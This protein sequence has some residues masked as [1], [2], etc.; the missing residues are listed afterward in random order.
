MKVLF[1]GT[2]AL[3]IPYLE[4]LL[5]NET[6]VGVV[7]RPDEPVGRGYEIAPPPTKKL[8]KEL[9]LPVFQP[10]GP[11]EPSLVQSL[12]GLG[13]EVGIVVA[14]GR[15]IP[16]DVFL[17][18]KLGSLNVH[19]SLLP[20][21]RG[22]APIQW[23][24]IRGEKE[25]GV[26]LFWLEEGLD[27]GPLFSQAAQVISPE[28]DALTLREKLV[29]LG[30]DLL[31]KAMADLK[32]GRLPRKPQEGEVILAPPLKKEDGV[33]DWKKPAEEIVNL[34]RGVVEWPV[35]HTAFKDREGHSKQLKIYKAAVDS[36]PPGR[37][38]QPGE[39][40]EG[41]INEGLLVQAGEGRLL[42]RQVQPESGKLM[43]AWAFWQ[44][45]RLP[46]GTVLGK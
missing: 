18:P 39:I 21:Y 11:W 1:F 30:V 23:S 32:A 33:I 27:S 4:W 28:D 29:P 45:A 10:K 22:A 26:S 15:I 14:Y 42:L 6:V 44:G 20:K 35:A 2:P 31:A 24:L 38:G 37:G 9:G 13:A 36:A 3:T 12:K 7:C 43:S 17:A 25:T 19:F 41:R 40:V 46:I 16:K 34:V 5:K 8:A